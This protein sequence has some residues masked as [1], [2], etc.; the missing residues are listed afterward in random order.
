VLAYLLTCPCIL[1]I[2]KVN[3]CSSNSRQVIVLTGTILRGLILSVNHLIEGAELPILV[4]RWLP[5]GHIIRHMNWNLP[6]MTF[7]WHIWGIMRNLFSFYSLI[8]LIESVAH[9]LVWVIGTIHSRNWG[10]SEWALLTSRSNFKF[11]H[12][13]GWNRLPFFQRGL[14]TMTTFC[15]VI[16]WTNFASF[17]IVSKKTLLWLFRYATS[18]TLISAW[19]LA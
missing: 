5:L 4:G 6:V 16:C 14:A 9:L 8:R 11:Y 15:V 12:I 7:A 18:H 2:C 13:E 10:I 17:F 3:C 1:F 19:L